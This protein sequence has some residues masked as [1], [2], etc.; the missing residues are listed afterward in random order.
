[1]IYYKTNRKIKDLEHTV[2][3]AT[4]LMSEKDNDI[5]K[6]ENKINELRFQQ[7]RLSTSVPRNPIG[8]RTNGTSNSGTKDDCIII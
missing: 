8:E 4:R 3:A 7:T 5:T 2:E 1:M 6:L